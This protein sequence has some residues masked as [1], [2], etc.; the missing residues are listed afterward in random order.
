LFWCVFTAFIRQQS[1]VPLT[2]P[3]S[4]TPSRCLVSG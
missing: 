2:A 4:F 1:F 3:R